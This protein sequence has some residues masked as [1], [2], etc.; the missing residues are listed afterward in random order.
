MRIT[1]R[2]VSA[3]RSTSALLARVAGAA[4][5]AIAFILIATQTPF[6]PRAG[7]QNAGGYQV[8]FKSANGLYTASFTTPQG[9]IRVNLPDDMA[10]GDTISG[11][12]TTEPNGQN[13][14]ERAQN[15]AE[16]KRHVLVIEGQQTP[17]GD[18]KFSW[19]IPR[20]LNSNSKNISLLQRGQ[21]VAT[22]TIPI[23]ATPPPTPSQFTIPTGGQEGRLIQIKGPGNGIFS[24]QD[25]V[26][27]GGKTM[28]PLAESPRSL[29]LRNATDSPGPTNIE[30]RENGV[31]MQCPFR[32]I[33]IN[34]S[35]PKLNLL[36]GETTT[37]HVV[38]VGLGGIVGDQSLD[39]ENTSPS[40]IKMSGGDRQHVNLRASEVRPDGTYSIDRTLT[41]IMAGSF[42]VTGTFRW[43]EVCKPLNLVVGPVTQPTPTRSPGGQGAARDKL[44]EGRNLLAHL[45]FYAAL[46][47]L[48]EALKSYRSSG[49]MNGI[50]VASDALGDLY[51]EEGQYEVALGYFQGA[52]QAFVANKETLNASLMISKIG[53]TYLLLDNITEAKGVFA[54]FGPQASQPPNSPDIVRHRTFFAYSRNKL[55]EGRA[56]YLLGQNNTA[57]SDFKD[58]LTAASSSAARGQEATRF[59]VAAATNLGDV[60]FRKGD[61]AAARIRYNEAIQLARRDR[62]TDLEW[63]AKAGLGRTLWALSERAPTTQLRTH[64]DP[65]DRLAAHASGQTQETAAKLRADAQNAYRDALTDIETVIEGSIR[66]HEARTTFLSTT[67]QVFEEAAALNAEMAMT[68]K[69]NDPT[70]S[71]G[72]SLRFSAEG[73]RISEQARA[74]SLLDVLADGHAEISAGVPPDLI[75]R[76]SEN[77]A[78]QQL[79]GTQLTGVSIAS[80]TPKQTF[81]D[82]EAELERLAVE[83]ESLENQIKSASPRLNS[84]VHTRALTLEE[85]QR[86]VLDDQTAL[87]EYSLGEKSSYLWVITRQNAALFK[88]PAGAIVDQL[89]MDLR[90]QLIP[91]KLQRRNVGIDVPTEDQQRGLG[92]STAPPATNTEAFSRASYALYKVALAPAAAMIGNRRLVIVA[93]GALNFVPFEALVTTDR[94]GD[95]S[96]LDYLIKTNKVSYAPS[97]SVTA[98]VR[99]QKRSAGRNVLLVADPVF[100]AS[101]AR[102]QTA[103][104]NS[105]VE[106]TRSLGLGSAVKDAT[107]QAT[108]SSIPLPRLAGTRIEAEQIGRLAKA[109]GS[110]GDLWLDLSANEADLKARDIQSYRVL[111]VATHGVLD[112]MRP[113]FSGLVLSLV[114]NKSDDD[115]YLRTSEVFNLKLGAPLV[116]L[117]ACESGLGKVKRGEGVIGLSRAFMYAG[118]T[119]VGVTLWSVADKPTAELMTDFYQR[120]LGPNPSPS[121]AIRGAQLSVISSKKYSAP[122]Y[123]APFVLVGEWK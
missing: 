104:A 1:N 102:L 22:T 11:T 79:I 59:R 75:K 55:G 25:Y 71:T 82:L 114:G 37:L 18:E 111:H 30:A 100:S 81:T 12:V 91:A 98:A 63:A 42:G 92:L 34:L 117:S 29:V 101:D 112:A 8:E 121:D 113:Q 66:G 45:K 94:A 120:L 4:L 67:R 51:L 13:D 119:T 78:N 24:P 85:V 77:L 68:G 65:I 89:A 86:R 83:F 110:Q 9:V 58:L 52:R 107:G 62:R 31:G 40:V 39:L 99:D 2:I 50:G 115:G 17:V 80:E 97:A 48:S 95:Y 73:F 21:A 74:R 69:G 23:A 47:P 54:Q 90:A 32:N 49:D 28:P 27:I 36:R 7:A 87:L 72:S 20:P 46:A 44:E 3:F 105:R 26:K 35:A 61:L 41:G 5:M 96:S 109:S 14:A 84:L 6:A 15:L 10:A 64:T 57:E 70:A 103:A 116:M 19:S 76:R 93:D 38:V 108:Q 33:G 122:F 123:W 118:A 106:V 60:L 56:D 16:L 53:E 43:N 88:L